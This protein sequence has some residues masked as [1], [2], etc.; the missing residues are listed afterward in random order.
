MTPF[1][2]FIP[3]AGVLR[4]ITIKHIHPYYIC[5]SRGTRPRQG[6]DSQ[7][8]GKYGL[9]FEDRT[10]LYNPPLSSTLVHDRG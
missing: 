9:R 7:I 2:Y 1:I 4:R 10:I 6:L 3:R 5:V 8:T